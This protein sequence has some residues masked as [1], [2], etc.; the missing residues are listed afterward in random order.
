MPL[1]SLKHNVSANFRLVMFKSQSTGHRWS[2]VSQ[3]IKRVSFPPKTNTKQL[4]QKS[5]AHFGSVKQGQSFYR[6]INV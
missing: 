4:K 6:F 1:V 3:L 5:E 2:I